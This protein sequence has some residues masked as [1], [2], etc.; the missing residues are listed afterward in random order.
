[1][2]KPNVNH[3]FRFLL[4]AMFLVSC[5]STA[6]PIAQTPIASASIADVIAKY[7]EEIPQQ[8]KEKNIPGL[9]IAV[10][11]DQGILWQES[12]GYTDWDGQTPVTS[13]TLFSIQSM[14]KSFTAT[15]AMFA[16]QDGLVDLDAPI[17][18]YLP[19]FHVNSIFEEHP[20]QKITLRIL[21]S[22]TAGFPHDTSYGNNN[23][24]PA[25]YSFEKHVASIADTW[26]MFPV[27]TRYNYS[28]EGIDLAGYILQVV[29]GMP[30]IQY[31]QEK[32][33]NPL[34]MKSSTLD[35][36]QVRAA[37]TRAIGHTGVPLRP[38]VDFL[39]IPSGGVWTNTADLA[40]YVQFHINQGEIDGTR[41]L[42]ADL[43]ETMYTPPNTAAQNAYPTSSY[44]LGITVSS[45]NG[46]QIMEHGGGGFGFIDD[47]AWYPELKLGAVVLSNAHQTE[48]YSFSL[49]MDVL[50]NIIVGNIPLY[51]QRYVNA[52]FTSPAYPTVTKG[53]NL[54]NDALLK[55]INSKALPGDAAALQRRSGYVGTYITTTWGF[56]D[57]TF[58]ISATNGDLAWIY[59]GNLSMYPRN[60]TLTEVEPGLFYTGNGDTFDLRGHTP[61]IDNIRLVKANPQALPFRIAL[62][63]VCGLIF[64]STLFF[65]PL[66]AVLR[67]I[68]RKRLGGNAGGSDPQLF[69]RLPWVGIL[70]ALA[71]LF[72]LFC[73]A[74]I[75]FLPNLIYVP[76]PR[77]F[78]DL[79]WW[80]FVLVGLPFVNLVLTVGTVLAAVLWRGKYAWTHTTFRYYLAVGLALLAFNLVILI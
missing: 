4:L 65:W 32:V 61:M 27:G 50:D 59:H 52:T 10:V 6:L 60:S 72:S 13:S 62:Y 79:L 55:L 47:M 30:F 74:L 16:A 48:S 28:N 58:E 1:M 11:D 25:E 20:E 40:R 80:Q 9:A 17:T 3:A 77:P 66:R 70:A 24:N 37:S 5:S 53:D 57:E 64:L 73:L 69:R 35:I 54:T 29:S 38:P 31:V 7:R 41:L 67:L 45:R 71:S 39:L 78:V 34:G 44:A 46:A 14:S 63:V 21:L 42:R 15:A 36:N 76:W 12:F 23:D 33:L 22:H 2:N 49:C 43:A 19:D 18:T 51:R 56:P 68:R 8:M 26:L 75:A